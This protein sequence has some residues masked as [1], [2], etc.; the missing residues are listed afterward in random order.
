MA[1]RRSWLVAIFEGAVILTFLVMTYRSWPNMSLTFRFLTVWGI[2]SGIAALIFQLSGSE[3]IEF[4]AE[5]LTI[6][7]EIHGWE[8]K[9][10]YKVKE[11]RELEWMQAAEDT[12][13]KMQCKIGHRKIAFGENLT[14]DQAIQI[15]TALQECLPEV[16]QQMCSYP[17]SKS[18]FITLGLG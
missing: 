16:A 17:G 2:L 12:P 7:K 11:C 9:R 18:H 5:N 15:L 4:D 6:T 10:E 1:R 14:E 13:P 8:R 3:I